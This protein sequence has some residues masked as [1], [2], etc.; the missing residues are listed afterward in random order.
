LAR[1]ERLICASAAL[2][3]A[4]DGVRFQVARHGEILPAF[5]VR[6]RATPFAYINECM[7]QATELDWNAGDFF[8]ESKLYLIC[9]SHGALY[10]PESG[11]CVA[12]PCRGARLAQVEVSERDGGIF[13]AQDG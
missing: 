12:G 4:G 3:D 2:V 10:E 5:V 9:A 6:W 13:C 11:L 8:D 1:G 7:H